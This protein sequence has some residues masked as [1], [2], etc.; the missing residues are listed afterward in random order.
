MTLVFCRAVLH[1]R[2]EVVWW[3]LQHTDCYFP[4]Y[5]SEAALTQS[6]LYKALAES[7]NFVNM[8][9]LAG[10]LSKKKLC[11]LSCTKTANQ[12]A[13]YQI[14]KVHS[15]FVSD[16]HQTVSEQTVGSP[17]VCRLWLRLWLGWEEHRNAETNCKIVSLCLEWNEDGCLTNWAK[18]LGRNMHKW[19][20]PQI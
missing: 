15:S 4:V 10:G 16:K 7:D 17:W 2:L 1:L 5:Y 19:Y 11:A 8:T 13:A 18:T 20:I 14:V 3:T 6:V 9:V 12:I